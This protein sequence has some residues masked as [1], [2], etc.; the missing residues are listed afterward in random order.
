MVWEVHMQGVHL[1]VD[2]SKYSNIGIYPLKKNLL[3][4]IE[5]LELPMR[6]YYF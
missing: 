3:F 5:K 6:T 1:L 2:V 4:S